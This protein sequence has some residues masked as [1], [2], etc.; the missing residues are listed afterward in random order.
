MKKSVVLFILLVIPFLN[1][2]QTYQK[3]IDSLKYVY[4]MPYI[5]HHIH[6]LNE[7][8]EKQKQQIGCGDLLFWKMF[9]K[10][11]SI[12][13]E[14]IDKLTDTTSTTVFV[15]NIGGYYTV[16][17][18]AYNAILEII[19]GI[20]TF[21]LLEIKP[22]ENTCIACLYWSHLRDDISNR[23]KIQ[24]NLRKWYSENKTKLVWVKSP[25]VLTGEC[26]FPHPNGGHYELIKD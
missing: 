21:E 8:E 13:P 26:S 7:L 19:K 22:K 14:L 2:A 1:K 6:N 23:K 9:Q 5:C 18:I 25:M 16:A 11:E 17:D 24:K 3:L 10:K 20:P 4:D 15:P 12:I